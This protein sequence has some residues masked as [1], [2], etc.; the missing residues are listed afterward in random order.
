M[1]VLFIPP[2][3]LIIVIF[4]FSK[5]KKS[6]L[7]QFAMYTLFGAIC[8]TVALPIIGTFFGFPSYSLMAAVLASGFLDFIKKY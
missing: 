1:E 5:R 3:V 6:F 4:L 8:S 2:T 7:K